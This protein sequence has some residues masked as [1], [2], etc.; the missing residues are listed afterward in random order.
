MPRFDPINSTIG[1]RMDGLLESE[2][3]VIHWPRI[4]ISVVIGCSVG[5][6]IVISIAI[7]VANMSTEARQIIG[8]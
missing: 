4:P 6:L 5:A 1:E 2:S 3:K 8:T 7:V